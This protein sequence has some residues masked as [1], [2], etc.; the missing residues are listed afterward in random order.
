[1]LT[2]SGNSKNEICIRLAMS[3][4]A[5]IKLE[6]ILR[7]REIEFKL[8]F[9]LYNTLVLSTLLYGCETWTLLE[10]AKM[11]IR[12]IESKAHRRLL[13]ISCKE[14]KTNILVNNLINEKVGWYVPLLDIIMRMKMTKF[15]HITRPDSMS[16]TNLQGY[17]EV[18]RK[19]ERRPKRNL[20]NDICEYSYLPL[21]K[22]LVIAKDRYNGKSC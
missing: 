21:Q 2:N 20:L 4:S 10:E 1:M 13:N 17:V 3:V 8:K 15:G 14:K 9:R 11:N 6:K 16:K 22:L 5:L 7:R 18:N 19:I 12:G